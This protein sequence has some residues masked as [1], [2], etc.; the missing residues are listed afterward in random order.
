MFKV[1]LLRIVAHVNK[2]LVKIPR[3]KKGSVSS[4][5]KEDA[6]SAYLGARYRNA[7]HFKVSSTVRCFSFTFLFIINF[8]F[9][10][11][12]LPSCCIHCVITLED[13]RKRSYSLE[14]YLAYVQKRETWCFLSS[15]RTRRVD[16]IKLVYIIN[17]KQRKTSAW[18][19][20]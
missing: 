17:H 6:L 19:C 20:V 7:K 10:R 4:L 1:L 2:T 3:L 13:L 11:C 8:S 16:R 12:L 18:R 9:F 14:Y 5:N 15:A